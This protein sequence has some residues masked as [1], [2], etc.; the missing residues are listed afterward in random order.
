[1]KKKLKADKIWKYKLANPTAT[2][3]QIAKACG[4]KI[5]KVFPAIVE[6]VN[7]E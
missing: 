3:R 1:M 6:M 7:Q 2:N 5:A 4:E